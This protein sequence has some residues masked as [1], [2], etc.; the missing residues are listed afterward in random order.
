MISID[1]EGNVSIQ[2]NVK[3]E[4]PNEDT[5]EQETDFIMVEAWQWVVLIF[6]LILTILIIRSSLINVEY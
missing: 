3:P 4:E 1:K 6:G 5:I 2:E